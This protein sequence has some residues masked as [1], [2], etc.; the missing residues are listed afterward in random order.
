M[1]VGFIYKIVCL[2]PEVKDTYVGSC[3]NMTKRKCQHKS[4]C[5]NSNSK[6]HNFNV[7]NFIREHGGWANWSIIAI[8]QVEYTI[9][10]E[11]L[12]RERFHL[13]RLK[14]SLNKVVPTRTNQE[15]YESNKEQI[16]EKQKAYYESNKQQI[17]E[18]A[19]Q[20]ITCECGKISNKY[21]I[22][23][24]NKSRR[25]QNYLANLPK[26]EITEVTGTVETTS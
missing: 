23:R 16:N 4:N 12:V 21:T 2:D 5:S 3:N 24:H 8:E 13:E 22:S 1:T 20:K 6:Y 26:V 11:L 7:Y 9:K 17:N 10:H 19:K 14:A 15:Y 25:H 18:K